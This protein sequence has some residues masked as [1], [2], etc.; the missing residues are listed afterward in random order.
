MLKC[1]VRSGPCRTNSMNINQL[2]GKPDN[3][4]AEIWL[5]HTKSD[6]RGIHQLNVSKVSNNSITARFPALLTSGLRSLKK[7]RNQHRTIFRT[8]FKMKC[9]RI[10]LENKKK[11]S[12]FDWVLWPVMFSPFA[13]PCW[14]SF[15]FHM[16]KTWATFTK[17]N[18]KNIRTF[19]A[20]HG[21]NLQEFCIFVSLWVIATSIQ[22]LP[23][24][25][26]PLV[27]NKPQ[28][29]AIV[30]AL[31]KN[32]PFP[33]LWCSDDVT[34]WVWSFKRTASHLYNKQTHAWMV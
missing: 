14:S 8:I 23:V 27:Q 9:G 5:L 7:D 22:P 11:K 24:H 16:S 2:W 4:E 15:K 34:K 30:L 3:P 25:S 33:C 10:L 17:L 1:K 31:D 13:C 19:L 21:S 20:I 28:L 26:L 6:G 18:Q 32:T 29:Q 12:L